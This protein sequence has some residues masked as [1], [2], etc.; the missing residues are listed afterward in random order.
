[1][2]KNNNK[3]NK[4]NRKK[5]CSIFVASNKL[6]FRHK[7]NHKRENGVQK[8]QGSTHRQKRVD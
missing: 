6:T 8:F 7:N 1:M 2:K 5:R 3:N 4:N